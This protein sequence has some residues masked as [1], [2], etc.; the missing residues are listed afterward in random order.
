MAKRQPFESSGVD[1]AAV[2]RDY[3]AG[4]LSNR[5]IAANHGITEAAIRKKAKAEGWIKGEPHAIRA[6]AMQKA[7]DAALPRY[8]EPSE[9]RIEEIAEQA[10]QVLIRH[11]GAA[12]VMA[13]LAADM[14]K[15]LREQTDCMPDIAEAIE[16]YFMAKAQANPVLAG[17]YKQQCNAA[18]HA[19]GLNNRSKT[20]LNLAGAV[21]KL[22]D[23]ERKAWSLDDNS[24][25]RS[26]E[27]LLAELHAKVGSNA[28]NDNAAVAA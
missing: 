1:W 9:E 6:R 16:D 11:R 2:E 8:M 17:A 5:A 4:V 3:R 15:Q 27:D 7:N 20:M 25:N 24:D 14:V 23:I 12:A 22:V 26:Y 19:I 21:A 13:G 10:S 28:A 18:L